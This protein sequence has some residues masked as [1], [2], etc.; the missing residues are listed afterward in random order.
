MGV[1]A[2]LL[3][4]TAHRR[5]LPPKSRQG[6]PQKKGDDAHEKERRMELFP[7]AQR[8]DCLSSEMSSLPESLQAELSGSFAFLPEIHEA[9]I[10]REYGSSPFGRGKQ[11]VRL[12]AGRW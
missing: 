9:K 1:N 2:A 4:K 5:F 12:Y 7:K 11:S 3:F 8:T 6:T 10:G